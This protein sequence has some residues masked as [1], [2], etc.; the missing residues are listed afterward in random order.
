METVTNLI[1]TTSIVTVILP[2]TSYLM[3]Y[4]FKKPH[5]YNINT[6]LPFGALSSGHQNFQFPDESTD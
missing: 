1:H 2:N 4:G 5:D 6:F 3:Y